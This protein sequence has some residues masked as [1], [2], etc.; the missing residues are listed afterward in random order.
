MVKLVER[1]FQCFELFASEQ[2]PLS[3]SEIARALGIP[4]SSCYDILQTLERLGYI[5]ELEPRGGYY[6][7]LRLLDIANSIASADPIRL[8]AEILLRSMR[9][10]LDESVF[11]SKVNGL[12]ATYLLGLQSSSLL[13]TVISPGEKLRSL[14]ATSAGK[15][16]LASLDKE[17][18]DAYFATADLKPLTPHSVTSKQ[19]LRQQLAA[20]RAHGVFTNRNESVEG[21]LSIS[22]TF[23]WNRATYI[24]S[25]IGPEVRLDGKLDWAR[26]MLLDICRRLEMRSVEAV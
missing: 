11:L 26:P 9:D 1:T 24:V 4:S 3:L 16:L 18:L 10:T 25:I 12:Q 20:G 19:A 6:P 17:A 13:R 8:R 21:V 7:T 14:H 23:Q 5:Y 22:A 2:R 15:A